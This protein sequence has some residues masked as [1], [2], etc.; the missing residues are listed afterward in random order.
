MDFFWLATE[1]GRERQADVPKLFSILEDY[2]TFG[3]GALYKDLLPTLGTRIISALIQRARLGTADGNSLIP[4]DVSRALIQ[5]G[6]D[7]PDGVL[8]EI[9]KLLED[10]IPEMQQIGMKVLARI[11]SANP[12]D[13]LWALHRQNAKALAEEKLSEHYFLY[14]ISF[15]ALRSCVQLQPQWL[16]EKA[17]KVDAQ[18][19]PVAELA[20]LVGSLDIISGTKIWA[21]VKAELFA[22]VSL[23]KPRCLI[24]CIR[25]F[26]DH[27]EFWRL[28]R[29]MKNEKDWAASS[30]PNALAVLHPGGALTHLGEVP[31]GERY[32]TRGWWL[33]ELLFSL[34]GETQS[35]LRQFMW[36]PDADIWRVALVYQGQENE[37]DPDTLDVFLD[38]LGE[39]LRNHFDS[40]TSDKPRFHVSLSLLARVSRWE[41]LRRFEARV[42]T[43]IET[44]LTDLACSWVGRSGASSDYDLNDARSVLL[45]IAGAGITGLVNCEVS[46]PDYFSRMAGLKWALCRPDI[47]TRQAVRKIMESEDLL[48]GES[49]VSGLRYDATRTLA[50][51]GEDKA[52]VRALLRW[53]IVPVD[54]AERRYGQLPMSDESL[55]EALLAL[56]ETDGDVRAH[57]IFAL[58]VSGREDLLLC[59]HKLLTTIPREGSLPLAAMFALN[60]LRDHSSEAVQFFA[61]QL[62]V[63]NHETQAMNALLR[64]ETEEALGAIEEHILQE[65]SPK[66]EH[67]Q[68]L[69][70]LTRFGEPSKRKAVVESI[71]QRIKAQSL[72]WFPHECFAVMGEVDNQE[73]RDLLWEKAFSSDTAQEHAGQVSAAI[74][75]PAKFDPDA[76]L[77]AALLALDQP[78]RNKEI[79]PS[80]PSQL[81]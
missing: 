68:A 53:G 46:S 32:G 80:A 35:K 40:G 38:A 23:D 66:F 37:M 3:S 54:L 6:G 15:S 42:D 74:R 47:V 64:I 55:S 5:I 45:K 73:I 75:G 61:D 28:E 41:L 58:G 12:L 70:A 39:D 4:Q 29:W 25:R 8:S 14:G 44:L 17:R 11:P 59:I 76:A 2:N 60:E 69:L 27:E 21:E 81:N 36:Q 10:P 16:V 9:T 24:N 52:L 57:A 67:F 50:A 7:S 65:S 78:Q 20:Y 13:R 63:P 77:R 43:E 33:P 26:K 22:K 56:D 18:E 30:A 62:T 49:Q 79:L 1:D 48:G 71:G 19:E 51:L 34:R 72:H 31:S